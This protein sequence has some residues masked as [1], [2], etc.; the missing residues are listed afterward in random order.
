LAVVSTRD[1]FETRGWSTFT[2]V[3]R[4]LD[5]TKA[6]TAMI[7]AAIAASGTIQLIDRRGLCDTGLTTG[8]SGE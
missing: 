3:W 5:G 4:G 1:V 7:A 8:M 6:S 2:L